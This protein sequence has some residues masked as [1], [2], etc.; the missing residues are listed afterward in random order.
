MRPG[1]GSAY[2]I[3]PSLADRLEEG[4]ALLAERIRR[5]FDPESILVT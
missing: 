3:E 4:A 5:A 1:V 2:T